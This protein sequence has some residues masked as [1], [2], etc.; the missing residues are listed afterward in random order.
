MTSLRKRHLQHYTA[1]LGATFLGAW[2]TAETGSMLPLACGAAV[3][4]MC[5]GVLVK[6]LWRGRR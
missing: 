5:T 2:L 4:V 6:S 3:A 1:G